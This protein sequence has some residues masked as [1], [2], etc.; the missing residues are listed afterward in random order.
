MKTI[1]LSML[2]LLTAIMP[3]LTSCSEDE[4]IVD[5]MNVVVDA[6]G[7]A[8]NDGAFEKLDKNSFYLDYIKYTIKEDRL[9][10]SGYDKYGFDGVAIILSS[11]T[12]NGKRYKVSEIGQDAF[13]GCERIVLA[14]IPSSVTEIARKAFSGCV[15]LAKII[16]PNSVV[17]IGAYAFEGCAGLA[18][19][20][21]PGS[22]VSIG[23]YAFY[24][25]T[26]LTSMLLPNSVMF[27][28]TS[29]FKDCTSLETISIGNS[30]MYQGI[31]CGNIAQSRAF[32]LGLK[33]NL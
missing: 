29:A 17:S 21:I 31:D 7:K 3:V 13:K 27:I 24:G 8:S 28:G 26:G 1:K 4:Q 6:N 30:V 32:V 15:N 22:V 18:S 11:I 23:A 25:C 20:T 2:L 12:Y 16:I 9:V 5:N 33:I 14:V 19:I 10:V